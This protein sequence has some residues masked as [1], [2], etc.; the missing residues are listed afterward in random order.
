MLRFVTS[1]TILLP[2]NVFVMHAFHAPNS[3]VAYFM[4][5]FCG[6]FLLAFIEHLPLTD[7]AAAD[8]KQSGTIYG[9]HCPNQVKL[10]DQDLRALRKAGIRI[11]RYTN[12]KDTSKTIDIDLIDFADDIDYPKTIPDKSSMT[13]LPLRGKNKRTTWIDP[14]K[15]NVA[16]RFLFEPKSGN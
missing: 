16:Y 9:V 14:S 6:N 3:W 5:T 2:M 12:A 13:M 8:M 4:A 11:L 10:R 1:Y 15:T 7:D